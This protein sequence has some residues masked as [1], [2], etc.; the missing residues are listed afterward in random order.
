[1]SQ[2]LKNTGYFSDAAAMLEWQAD[3]GADALVEDTPQAVQAA[4]VKPVALAQ[5]ARPAAANNTNSS[6]TPTPTLTAAIE[7]ARQ[8]ADAAKTLEELEAAVRNFT[9][10]AL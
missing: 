9:G 4:A 1:M 6:G 5:S 2:P 8:A 10:C 3:I 7:D